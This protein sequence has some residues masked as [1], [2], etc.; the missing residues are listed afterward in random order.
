MSLSENTGL[1]NSD[2]NSLRRAFRKFPEIEKVVLFGSRAMGNFKKGSDI[3]IA[4][5]G[6]RITPRTAT[7]LSAK[8]NEDMPLPYFIEV[9][10]YQSLTNAELKQHIDQFGKEIYNREEMK[11]RKS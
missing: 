4:I 8:L 10:N 5:S 2:I 6:C 11:K 9:I 7:K 1:L 3:D